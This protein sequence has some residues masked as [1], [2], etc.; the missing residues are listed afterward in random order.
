MKTFFSLFLAFFLFSTVTFSQTYTIG[1]TEY[2]STQTYSTSGLPK[3]K[4]SAA[5]KKA[6]LESRGY[7]ST[8]AGYEIDHIIPLSRG[9]SD[10]PYNMQLLTVE[11]HKAKTARER[12]ATTTGIPSF[13]NSRSTYTVPIYNTSST[14]KIPT[15]NTSTYKVPESTYSVPSY[16]VPSYSAPAHNGGRNIQR[17]SRGGQYYINSNGNKT[18]IKK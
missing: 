2:Y 17:G 6:F 18:Y 9:G 5:N 7:S 8:P 12:S 3:V 10:S 1:K 15:Y 16:S 13:T 11:Q 14:H 4:R